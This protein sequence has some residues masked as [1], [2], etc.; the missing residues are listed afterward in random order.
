MSVAVSTPKQAALF[1]EPLSIQLTPR[2]GAGSLRP[3]YVSTEMPPKS[4]AKK[5]NSL[6]TKISKLLINADDFWCGW[7]E[8]NPRPLGS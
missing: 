3:A 2:S 7:Q 1:P 6:E 4:A 5:T 8:S